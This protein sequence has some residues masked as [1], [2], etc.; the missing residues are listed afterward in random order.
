MGQA[1]V[2]QKDY[3]TEKTTFTQRSNNR[4]DRGM[5]RG[6]DVEDNVQKIEKSTGIES[7]KRQKYHEDNE[8]MQ[9]PTVVAASQ[10]H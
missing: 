2:M 10:P 3:I 5:K 8:N 1:G 9:T 4:A 6:L 7:R